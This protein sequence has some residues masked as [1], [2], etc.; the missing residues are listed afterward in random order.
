[1]AD[2]LKHLVV[3][4]LALPVGLGGYHLAASTLVADSDGVPGAAEAADLSFGRGG[5]RLSSLPIL[6]RDLYWLESRYVE[7]ERLDPEQMYQAALDTVERE[8][9]EVMFQREPEGRRLHV[10][11]GEY[12]TV[13]LVDPMDGFG[14]MA[15]QLRQVAAILDEHL[16]A[17]VDRHEVEY[18]LVNG[19]LSTLDPHTILMPPEV[20][21]E[22]DVDNK[23]EFGGLGIEITIKDGRLTVKQPI[24]DTPAARAGM[25]ADDRIVRIDDESTI[26]MDLTDAVRKLRGRKGE[27]VTI[28]VMRKGWSEPRPFV[29]VRDMIKINP[30]EGQLL[31]GAVGYI[32]IKSFHAGVGADLDDLLTRFKR[33]TGG[34]IRG[35]V[36]DLRGNPGGYLTEAVLVSDKF[37]RDGVIVSTVDGGTG[38]REE[39]R[40]SR[41]GTAPDFPIA[42]LVNGNSASASEIVAGALRNQDRAVIL[43][44][45]TFGKGSVQNLYNHDDGSRLKLTVAKY[46]TPGDQSIQAIGI[47]P[48]IELRPAV[49]EPS[50]DPVEDPNPVASLYWREWLD[51]E[52]DLD[53]VLSSM[54]LDQLEPA[55]TLRYLQDR[56][57]SQSEDP[58]RDWEVRLAREILLAAPGSRRS[59]VLA[60]AGP[61]IDRHLSSEEQHLVRAFG[62]IGVDWSAGPTPGDPSVELRLDLGE[63]GVLRAG[64]IEDVALLVTN[65]G[66][67]PLYRL[68][69]VSTSDNPYL[70][71]REFY[72]GR[73]D[74]GETGQ[75]SVRVKVQE[76]YP[77]EVVPVTLEL[78]SQDAGTVYNQDTLVETVGRGLPTFAYRVTMHDGGTDGSQGD[79]D[80]IPEVGEVVELELEVLNTGTGPTAEA[81]A[82][83]KNRSGRHLDLRS[84]LVEVGEPRSATGE[85]CVPDSAGCKRRLQPGERYTGRMSFELREQ[86]EE[87]GWKLDLQVGDNRAYDYATVQRAGFFEYFQLEE[88]IE[89]QPGQPFDN[90]PRQPPQLLVT[91]APEGES[92]AATVVISGKATDDEALRDLMVFH[93]GDKVF[94]RGGHGD[95]RTI[96]FSVERRLE[97]GAN[98]VVIL[99]RDQRGLSATRA[100]STWYE[101]PAPAA[102]AET[103]ANAG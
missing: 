60:A 15:A 1:M 73:L 99:V 47:P 34:P 25:K 42:V 70:D 43:G 24:A 71:H 92:Q 38:R 85:S 7:R 74:P 75:V 41:A 22:M 91:R 56:D 62:D 39:Q 10:S 53:N 95:E 11:V 16:P 82:R 96:P 26:N 52:A 83:V 81:F 103:G 4:G 20:A 59:D 46:M 44:E 63:D 79:G 40:A 97:P 61:V 76:G 55:W 89:L 28:M 102:R 50:E 37:L 90:G 98:T 57:D 17:D 21:D 33:E 77:S 27:P 19:A 31:E 84:G 49:V 13:L 86:P 45:R 54:T 3:L 64:E 6:E 30:V 35:L 65:T 18:S 93:E 29:I 80:G 12:S 5:Y 69:A 23:G 9:A 8:Y 32:R 66:S 51:R 72:L 68:S 48:D 67:E 94:F 36:L 101:E 14:A 58:Q 78:R 87:G 2:L 100:I 88:S